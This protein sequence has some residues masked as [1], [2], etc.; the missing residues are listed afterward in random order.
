MDT[1]NVPAGADCFS[2]PRV[3][4]SLLFLSVYGF[5]EFRLSP[6]FFFIYSHPVAE[7]VEQQMNQGRDQ[8]GV[9]AVKV[10]AS[11]FA[12]RACL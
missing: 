4:L 7:A 6:L 9:V 5:F 1:A 11:C 8:A 10:N 2:V 12:T 3:S